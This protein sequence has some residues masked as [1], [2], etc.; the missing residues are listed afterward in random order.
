M[1]NIS[2]V[3]NDFR[4]GHAWRA[5]RG[6]ATKYYHTIVEG[7]SLTVRSGKGNN[8]DPWYKVSRM[9]YTNSSS[10]DLHR[11]II[12]VEDS[13]EL[14]CDV[15]LVQYRF[16]GTPHD[17]E[18]RPHGNAKH[19]IP[20][21]PTK[22]TVIQQIAKAVATQ[23]SNKRVLH[24]IEEENGGLLADSP[25]HLPR[26]L[27]QIR[28]QKRKLKPLNA[29]PILEVMNM[30]EEQ[31]TQ[32]IQRIHLDNNS[33]TV[34]LFNEEQISDL[35]R[36]CAPDQSKQASIFCCDMTFK[37]G[38]FWV[39]ITT[40]H[41]LQVFSKRCL[42]PVCMI[43]PVMICKKKTREQYTALFQ[44]ITAQIPELRENLR[45]FGQDGERSLLDA[46]ILE[47]PF[48]T[49]FLDSVH[50]KRNIEYHITN[51]M[52]LSNHFAAMVCADVFGNKRTE[53]LYHCVTRKEFDE[54]VL[55]LKRKWNEAE[56]K[57]RKERDMPLNPR[58][59]NYF[60]KNKSELMYT[61]CREQVA[62]DANVYVN[63]RIN[64]QG[65]ESLNNCIKEWQ[66]Y[67]KED[68]AK[69]VRS[70]YEFVTC[71]QKEIRKPFLGIHSEFVVNPRYEEYIRTGFWNSNA[72]SRAQYLKAVPEFPLKEL[73]VET[74]NHTIKAVKPTSENLD[75]IDLLVGHVSEQF[76]ANL[77]EKVRRLRKSIRPGFGDEYSRIV[78]SESN[79]NSMHCITCKKNP[80]L[81][82][83]DCL[84]FKSF[85]VCAH[86]LLAA[87]DNYVLREFIGNIVKAPP[88]KR[89]TPAATLGASKYAGRKSSEP[90]RKRRND[91]V[92][93]G[94]PIKVKLSEALQ[95]IDTDETCSNFSS[96]PVDG[97]LKLVVSRGPPRTPKPKTPPTLNTPF[98]MIDITGNIRKCFGCKR[99]LADGPIKNEVPDKQ[100][101]DEKICI[102]HKQVDY[103]FNRQHSKW[104]QKRENKHFHIMKKCVIDGN[105][106]HFN[107][108]NIDLSMNQNRN[109]E[110][111]EYIRERLQES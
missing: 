16:D 85:S 13:N 54:N 74:Q 48:A 24:S 83:C 100:P 1:V 109:A 86:S 14:H 89:Y 51:E 12:F 88:Q 36:F 58:F 26:D 2:D 90:I 80:L 11:A 70:I 61:Y 53:G 42:K 105:N 92:A 94:P 65:T 10:K 31:L 25:S 103:F 47:F 32:F 110:F 21:I 63:S 75:D 28:Y 96:T 108:D 93:S 87:L 106:P 40:F 19:K 77:K 23:N 39:V 111:R 56:A 41:N 64:N 50:I 62:I 81:F 98:E 68:M 18:I 38:D 27:N 52:K 72:D 107:P 43:G 7:D 101:L 29:D 79:L 59:S 37:L 55:K 82:I 84:N 9:R 34:I 8:D 102:R 22:E 57:E 67:Q 30:K 78:K 95:E 76:A 104:Q 44:A 5:T 69:F 6:T 3:G 97:G 71:Q 17:I 15:A 66:Q 4:D 20:F 45:A 49:G 35:K 60:L 73:S 99:T 33:P 46:N 91:K